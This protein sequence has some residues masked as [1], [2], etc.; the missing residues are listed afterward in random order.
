MF[1]TGGR[2]LTFGLRRRTEDVYH[3]GYSLVIAAIERRLDD[4]TAPSR[5][6]TNGNER[7]GDHHYCH[8][9]RRKRRRRLLRWP[10]EPTVRYK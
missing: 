10:Q 7:D 4:A 3:S 6:V 9:K 5:D 2:H 8:K 1:L